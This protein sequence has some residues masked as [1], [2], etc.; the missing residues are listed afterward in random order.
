[1]TLFPLQIILYRTFIRK[2][3]RCCR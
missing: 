2:T 1:M 3:D